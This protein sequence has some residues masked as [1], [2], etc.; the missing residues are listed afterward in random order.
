MADLN[1]IIN[2]QVNFGDGKIKVDNLTTSINNLSQA[3]KNLGNTIV[4]VLN[5]A[6]L[7]TEQVI[8]DE[9]AALNKQRAAIAT[10]SI[11]YMMFTDR[12]EQLNLEMTKLQGKAL[13][14]ATKGIGGLGKGMKNLRND[15]G[16]AAQTLVEVG[17][18]ISDAN[19]GF[20]AVANNLSQLGQYFSSLIVQSGGLKNTIASLGNQ[21]LGAGGLMIAFQLV[22]FAIEKF[23][24]SQK[25]A[26]D[27]A[28]DLNKT[29]QEQQDKLAI[30][31]KAAYGDENYIEALK[32]NFSELSGYLDNLNELERENRDLVERGVT[33]QKELIQVRIAQNEQQVKINEFNEKHKNLQRLSIQQ[34]LEKNQL[35]NDLVDLYLKESKLLKILNVEK[36]EDVEVTGKQ[37]SASEKRNR[38]FK[39]G[40]LNLEQLE[41]RYRQN[42]LKD[43]RTTQE[44]LLN[45]KREAAIVDARIRYSTF[46]DKQ[47]IRYENYIAEE[48]DE[49]K[50]ADATIKF[51]NSQA[52]AYQQHNNVISAI[53]NSFDVEERVLESRKTDNFIKL[54]SDRQAAELSSKAALATND[55]DRIDAGLELE[56]AKTA[57]R[58]RLIEEERDIRLKAGQDTYI[59]DQQLANE[60]DALK[61]KESKAFQDAEQAKLAIANQVGEAIIAIAGEGS[62]IGKAVAVAMA[63]MNTYEAVTAALGAK[64]YGP[65]NIA[66]AAAVGAMG[67]VQVKNI[68]KTEVPSPSGGSGAGAATAPSIQPPDFNIVG[69][70]ASNQL[71]AAVQGQFNQ[72]VKAYVV[73]K[74][75]STAQEMDRNIV[76]TAS[77]G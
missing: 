73:S 69:Q 12:I 47:R 45:I 33:A 72:P 62:A 49:K 31:N 14:N 63:T 8:K 61:Q 1:K 68:L 40:V 67:F 52:N 21:M 41:E 43:E 28:E 20:T 48:K 19:Y 54:L 25:K 64:P 3:K 60:R 17:R 66:Q 10:T 36:T 2:I 51:L 27:A 70:S 42:S 24:L 15:S 35:E 11:Q 29:L 16:L 39:E 53:N 22:I 74:D 55:L 5:P 18:T 13:Q 4:G 38:L 65:W 57:D 6:F 58:V 34:D 9:I 32:R 26:K 23:T 46:I 7:R 71:A 44:E 59:Q 75:V 30:L 77:L 37:I 56:R 50:R 76:S